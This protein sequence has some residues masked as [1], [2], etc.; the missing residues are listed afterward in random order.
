MFASIARIVIDAKAAEKF[1]E[2]YRQIFELLNVG[3]SENGWVTR[4]AGSC[5]L[6][7]HRAAI[8]ADHRRAAAKMVF[9]VTDVAQAKRTLVARGFR[10]GATSLSLDSNFCTGRDPEG[11]HLSIGDRGVPLRK[12]ALTDSRALRDWSPTRS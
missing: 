9:G 5:H 4:S 3:E 11:N 12:R 6:A 7:L 1:A 10:L 2:F 8:T